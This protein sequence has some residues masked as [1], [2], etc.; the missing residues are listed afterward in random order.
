MRDGRVTR[1][2]CV[3]DRTCPATGVTGISYAVGAD[4]LCHPKTPN[5]RVDGCIDNPSGATYVVVNVVDPQAS[6]SPASGNPTTARCYQYEN[7]C[8]T[9]AQYQTTAR[10]DNA[11]QRRGAR[12]S[13]CD[14]RAIPRS[15]GPPPVADSG[16]TYASGCYTEPAACSATGTNANVPSNGVTYTNNATTH[17]CTPQTSCAST[18]VLAVND[19][20]SAYNASTN[21]DK[22]WTLTSASVTTC[23]QY[24]TSTSQT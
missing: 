10:A 15:S 19:A 24:S 9:P 12:T 6:A 20:T 4:N 3:Y 22:C 18:R 21:P 14:R 1:A 23:A 16:G 5:N 11:S 7:T 13:A 2:A 8:R 17:M